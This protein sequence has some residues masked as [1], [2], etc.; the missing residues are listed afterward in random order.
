MVG[1]VGYVVFVK[2]TQLETSRLSQLLIVHPGVAGLDAKAKQFELVPGSSS[3]YATVKKS[4]KSDPDETGGVARLWEGS[5]S[6]H[7]ALTLLVN[8]L[9]D[10]AAARSTRAEAAA[11]D[12]GPSSYSSEHLTFTNRFGVPG[13]PGALGSAYA[14][15]ASSTS[16]AGHGYAVV[17]R[18]GRTVV[19]EL[20]QGGTSTLTSVT[21]S[22]SPRPKG[23]CSSG[24]NR[25]SR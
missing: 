11:A 8:L 24:S 1:A 15:A 21:P 4:A 7:N 22:R 23:R 19:S 5:S 16:V 20:V 17:F 10:T 6:S 14:E 25:G 12:L 9:P 18:V 13:V 3:S 2:R